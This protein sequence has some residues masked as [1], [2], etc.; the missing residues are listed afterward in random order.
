M[1]NDKINPPEGHANITPDDDT[2]LEKVIAFYVGVSGDLV[3]ED[4]A[5][6]EATYL[7]APAGLIIP[8]QFT[9][10]KT[11]TTATNIVAMYGDR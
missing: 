11:G 7:S 3:A 2:V 4:P 1:A 6:V 10:L 5:G 8:G 9:K